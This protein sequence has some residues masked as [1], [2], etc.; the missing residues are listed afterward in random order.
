[1]REQ[2]LELLLAH[3][4]PFSLQK[5]SRQPN[6]TYV[7]HIYIANKTL[8]YLPYGREEATIMCEAGGRVFR[9]S[10]RRQPFFLSTGFKQTFFLFGPSV[11]SSV[12]HAV[13]SLD[14]SR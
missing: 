14:L 13:K 10:L 2:P 12:G 5:G 7:R 8:R 1:M 11:P 9:T 3:E 4:A 6:T